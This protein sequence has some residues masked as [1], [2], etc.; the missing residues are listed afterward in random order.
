MTW[1]P[2]RYALD[3]THLKWMFLCPSLATVEDWYSSNDMVWTGHVQS[4][5]PSFRVHVYLLVLICSVYF[6]WPNSFTAF[7]IRGILY[8]IN[9]KERVTLVLIKFVRLILVALSRDLLETRALLARA[10]FLSLQ[11]GKTQVYI[12]FLHTRSAYDLILI[13]FKPFGAAI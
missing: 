2:K 11:W 6:M 7:Q 12:F 13:L 1:F 10:N 8:Q 9:L 5:R 4:E 3:R